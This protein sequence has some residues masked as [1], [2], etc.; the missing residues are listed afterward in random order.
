MSKKKL[1]RDLLTQVSDI[2]SLVDRFFSVVEVKYS[3]SNT[4]GGVVFIGF[5]DY[6]WKEPTGEALSAQKELINNYEEWFTQSNQMISEAIPDR[7]PDFVKLYED[8]KEIIELDKKIW[9]DNTESFKNDFIRNLGKQK[10]I[11]N[12]CLKFID[13]YPEKGSI[14]E[15][16]SDISSSMIIDLK[17]QMTILSQQYSRI[18]SDLKDLSRQIESIGR[19]TINNLNQNTARTGPINISNEN[20]IKWV[21][22]DLDEELKKLNAEVKEKNLEKSDEQIIQDLIK[23][24]LSEE[25]PKIEWLKDKITKIK[26]WG[27]KVGITIKRLNELAEALGV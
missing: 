13:A 4:G 3:P 6:Y 2:E 26:Y 23:T 20:L 27:N 21:K 11:L 1:I 17:A 15:G 22:P 12:S 24:V 9:S 7:R 25:N 16:N 18:E 14:Q 5:S 10:S 8:N 19:V